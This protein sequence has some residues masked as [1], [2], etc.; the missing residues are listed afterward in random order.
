M[1]VPPAETDGELYARARAGDAAAFDVLV[2][3][4]LPAVYDFAAAVAGEAI[5]RAVT[6]A[7]FEEQARALRDPR[8][9]PFPGSLFRFARAQVLAGVPAAGSDSGPDILRRA[10]ALGAQRH[11]LLD[12]HLRQGFGA[13]ELAAVLGVRKASA[14]LVLARLTGL[15]AADLAGAGPDP[16]AAYAALPRFAPPPGLLEET[17]ERV[18]A[19]WTS[20]SPAGDGADPGFVPAPAWLEPPPARRN[21]LWPLMPVLAGGALLLG[22]LVLLPASPVALTR[23]SSP[24]HS[25]AASTDTGDEPD[26]ARPTAR[27]PA[28]PTATRRAG[29]SVTPSPRTTPTTAAGDSEATPT[30]TTEDRRSPTP[31]ASPTAT[32]RTATPSPTP[33]ATATVPATATPTPTQCSS[34]LRSNLNNGAVT[35]PPDGRSSFVILNNFCGPSTFTVTEVPEADWLELAPH[36]G[37]IASGSSALVNLHALTSEPGQYSA[38]IEVQNPTGSSFTVI[39]NYAP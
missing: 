17:R 23:Q 34:V 4:W 11:A 29:A 33:T 39:V 35:M 13:A 12:L 8:P 21:L 7:V 6:R 2:E 38:V 19:A 3:R 26:P 37:T 20:W 28:T 14:E 31:T 24:A 15:S 5:A 16:L 30:P 27:D 36:S 32:V 9:R 25:L 22:L 18:A 10:R 1:A